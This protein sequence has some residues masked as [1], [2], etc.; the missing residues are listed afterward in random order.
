MID[1]KKPPKRLSCG[2]DRAPVDHEGRGRYLGN[3]NH[4]S[5]LRES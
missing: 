5:T 3:A 4:Q 2:E 1:T